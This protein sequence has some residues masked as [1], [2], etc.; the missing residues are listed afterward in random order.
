MRL[1][2]DETE[3]FILWDLA[4]IG[5]VT[6][7]KAGRVI[8]EPNRVGREILEAD[9]RGR[10]WRGAALAEL[11]APPF[12]APF[13]ALGEG[14][15]STGAPDALDGPTLGGSGLLGPGGSGSGSG[16]GGRG[17]WLTLSARVFG[18]GQTSPYGAAAIVSLADVSAERAAS[19]AL[20]RQN[21]ALDRA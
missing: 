8:G 7:D 5:F 17:R 10:P 4:P 2:W 20:E 19:A 15:D 3:R 13:A 1:E 18:G 16:A 6:L 21:E 9:L 11:L 14:R 12:R